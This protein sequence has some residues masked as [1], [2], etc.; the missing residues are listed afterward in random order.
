M[1]KAPKAA[2]AA[3]N[4]AAKAGAETSEGAGQ[5]AILSVSDQ[6]A[7]TTITPSEEQTG[8]GGDLA[9]STQALS[10]GET[11]VPDGGSV[12][13]SPVPQAG[14]GDPGQVSVEAASPQVLPV[15]PPVEVKHQEELFTLALPTVHGGKLKGI[16]ETVRLTR[17][18]HAAFVS[19]RRVA[20]PWPDATT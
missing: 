16:G 19:A 3:I 1:A 17:E 9:A 6:G 20:E 11:G 18:T 15:Q 4:D 2:P 10:E 5:S 14:T 8:G 12:A 13:G 7:T